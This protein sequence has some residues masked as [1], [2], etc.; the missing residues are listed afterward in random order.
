M[1]REFV[2]EGRTFL[3]PEDA[4][5]EEVFTYVENELMAEA[6]KDSTVSDPIGESRVPSSVSTEEEKEATTAQL[7]RKAGIAGITAPKTSA[8]YLRGEGVGS[9]ASS[10][11]DDL[12]GLLN[13]PTR[14]A[15]VSTG[16]DPFDPDAYARKPVYEQKMREFEADPNKELVPKDGETKK[17]YLD[18]ARKFLGK[19]EATE[20]E[21]LALVPS[22]PS[23]MM[24]QLISDPSLVLGLAQLPIK[25]VRKG[26]QWLFGKMS[27]QPQRAAALD[28]VGSKGGIERVKAAGKNLRERILGASEEAGA[29]EMAKGAALDAKTLAKLSKEAEAEKLGASV[30]KSAAQ[31][32]DELSKFDD[33]EAR[34]AFYPEEKKIESLVKKLPTVDIAP[35]VSKSLESLESLAKVV[36]PKSESVKKQIQ[37]IYNKMRGEDGFSKSTKFF[38]TKINAKDA[39]SLRR[40]IDDLVKNWG[41][42]SSKVLLDKHVKPLR[43]SIKDGLIESAVKSGNTE[44]VDTMTRWSDKIDAENELFDL[45]STYTE[46]S[47]A[48]SIERLVENIA[49]SGKGSKQEKEILGKVNEFFGLDFLPEPLAA[50]AKHNKAEELYKLAQKES[51]LA[52][53]K[54]RSAKQAAKLAGESRL[55]NEEIYAELLN[56][57]DPI[58][59]TSKVT[60][61]ELERGL[62]EADRK[63]ALSLDYLSTLVDVPA[64]QALGMTERAAGK[65]LKYG[66]PAGMLSREYG[67]LKEGNLEGFSLLPPD[68]IRLLK[69]RRMK[70]EL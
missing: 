14:L 24:E 38:K 7:A 57:G 31:Y 18:R 19:P 64:V 32:Y 8:S 58:P 67:N 29:A 22:E 53:V 28:V 61:K 1:A 69:A 45:L 48:A 47:K 41:D 6:P 34:K 10:A 30:K 39:L 23:E 54:S 37:Y 2:F 60:G 50:A 25:G 44:Y 55:S 66:V 62:Q 9:I 40:E 11:L 63:P 49:K 16:Q 26:A 42:A 27:G 46:P 4:T 33:F 20:S 59:K 43:K 21:I 5:D 52:G 70:E 35:A 15:S 13:L 56:I 3:V 65:S 12:I 36:D 68:V 51:A 17:Q